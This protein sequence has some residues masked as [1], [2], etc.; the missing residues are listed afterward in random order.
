MGILSSNAARP[1]ISPPITHELSILPNQRTTAAPT[2]STNAT[3]AVLI[4]ISFF[5]DPWHKL[6]GG[7]K[8]HHQMRVHSPLR[9]AVLSE[10]PNLARLWATRKS[11]LGDMTL[12]DC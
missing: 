9:E 3:A 10:R 4:T 5:G 2:M 6:R 11:S 12:P 8:G 7:E 1:P